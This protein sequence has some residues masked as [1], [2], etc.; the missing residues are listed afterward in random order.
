VAAWEL[1]AARR[2]DVGGDGS[3]LGTQ[4]KIN[5]AYIHRPVPI[6]HAPPMNMGHLYSS[7]M[8]RHRRI[9]LTGQSQT[10]QPINSLVPGPNR[11]TYTIFIGLGYR[12]IYCH[13]RMNPYFL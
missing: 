11:R 8:W 6:S 1:Q 5:P 9:Y 12:R 10:G 13:Q 7:V 2:G 4:K 3:K